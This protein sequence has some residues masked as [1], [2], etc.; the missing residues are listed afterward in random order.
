[1]APLTNCALPVC[2][3]VPEDSLEVPALNAELPPSDGVVRR[4]RA[5]MDPVRDAAGDVVKVALPVLGHPAMRSEPGHTRFVSSS[6]SFSPSPFSRAPLTLR[7]D[8]QGTRDLTGCPALPPKG[9]AID[10][11]GLVEGEGQEGTSSKVMVSSGSP[12]MPGTEGVPM[13]LSSHPPALPAPGCLDGDPG[14]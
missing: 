8:L 14:T 5:P 4:I 10:V 13:G 2:R 3:M 1:M 11:T 12:R 6:S 9:A 7:G